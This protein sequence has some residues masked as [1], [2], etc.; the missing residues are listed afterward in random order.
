M[1]ENKNEIMLTFK[2]KN[3]KEWKIE[4]KAHIL[5]TKDDYSYEKGISWREIEIEK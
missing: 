2:R 3:N 5:K 4:N 1:R